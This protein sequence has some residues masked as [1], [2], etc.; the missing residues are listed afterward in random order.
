MRTFSKCPCWEECFINAVSLIVSETSFKKWLLPHPVKL[1]CTREKWEQPERAAQGLVW[2]RP[3]GRP[4]GCGGA[5]RSRGR[6]WRPRGRAVPE[7]SFREGGAPL[8]VEGVNLEAEVRS[9]FTAEGLQT[10]CAI[11]TVGTLARVL[12]CLWGEGQRGGKKRILSRLHAAPAP[13]HN[14]RSP[15][16]LKSGVSLN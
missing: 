9:T 8:Q 15:P 16:E 6:G 2:R 14:P 7:G 3:G 10:G 12:F 11:F 4:R 5:G 1:G 13:S